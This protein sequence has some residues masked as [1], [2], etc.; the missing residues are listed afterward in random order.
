MS[1]KRIVISIDIPEE[2]WTRDGFGAEES[3]AV[4]WA[5][6]FTEG[7]FTTEQISEGCTVTFEELTV[8]D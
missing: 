5:N 8:G 6:W 1:T 7:L 4:G 2:V 3:P